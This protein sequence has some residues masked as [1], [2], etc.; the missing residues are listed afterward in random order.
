MKKRKELSQ[1]T[2][3]ILSVSEVLWFWARSL[4]DKGIWFVKRAG[5]Q[6]QACCVQVRG[7]LALGIS[8]KALVM[9]WSYRVPPALPVH[10]QP[11]TGKRWL[12]KWKNQRC[13]FSET[14]SQSLPSFPPSNRPL[15]NNGHRGFITI[16]L[17]LVANFPQVYS[18]SLGLNLYQRFLRN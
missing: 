5:T 17:P 14:P 15:G 11:W 8:A 12:G 18:V 4:G 13:H 3:E 7:S 1:M 10:S 16:Q 2:F 9:V 6:S